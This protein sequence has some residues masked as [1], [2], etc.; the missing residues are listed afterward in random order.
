MPA[1]HKVDL[2]VHLPPGFEIDTENL[3]LEPIQF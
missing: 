1:N 3:A 2:S